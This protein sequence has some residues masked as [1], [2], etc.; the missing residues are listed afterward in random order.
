LLER[1][2]QFIAERIADTL[3]DGEIGILFMGVLHHVEDR[4]ATLQDP[5]ASG[6]KV[7]HPLGK[8]LLGAGR[9]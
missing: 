6:I 5:A 1:R 7:M 8:P 9:Q 4:L 2:D 3:K